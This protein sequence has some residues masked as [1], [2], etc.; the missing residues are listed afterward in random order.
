MA[1][2]VRDGMMMDAT[3]TVSC[4]SATRIALS[5]IHLRLHDARHG[6]REL[7]GDPRPHEAGEMRRQLP[8][9]QQRKRRGDERTERRMRPHHPQLFIGQPLGKLAFALRRWMLVGIGHEAMAVRT[10]PC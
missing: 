3:G 5:A 7:Q 8:C 10:Q 4:T 6:D 9:K 1:T 2:Q